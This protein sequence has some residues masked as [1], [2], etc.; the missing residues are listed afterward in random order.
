MTGVRPSLLA[1][2]VVASLAG[3]DA[4]RG[5]GDTNEDTEVPAVTTVAVETIELP[6]SLRLPGVVKPERRAVLSTRTS[7][8]VETVSVAA[9]D[10]VSSGRT[11]VDV[12][13]RDLEAALEAARLRRDAAAAALDKADRDVQR[14]EQLY[15]DELIALSRL[16]D[17]R[18]LREQRQAELSAARAAVRARRVGLDYAEIK[19]PFDGIV[20]EVLVDAG[21][22]V[23]PGTPLLVLEAREAFEVDA[24]VTQAIADRLTKGRPVTVTLPGDDRRYQGTVQAVIPALENG[25]AGSLVRIA[26]EGEVA[27]LRPGQVVEVVLPSDGAVRTAWRVPAEAVFRRGQLHGVFVAVESEQGFQARLRWVTL[28]PEAGANDGHRLVLEG[29]DAGERVVVGD[30]PPHLRDG[31]AIRLTGDG[32]ED[33]GR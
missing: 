29:L 30:A 12:E 3:C 6:Q 22:F 7:G 19:A 20:S 2:I 31:Q 26:I 5:T 13:S 11:L 28:E 18:L 9:G 24:S 16:E 32:R 14:L 23:G 10:A 25:G 21:T 15:A 1:S 17:A 33:P 4:G 27:G 8:I